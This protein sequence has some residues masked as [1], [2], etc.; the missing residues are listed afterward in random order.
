MENPEGHY[1][2]LGNQL[3]ITS[4]KT[5]RRHLPSDKV[6]YSFKSSCSSAHQGWWSLSEVQSFTN[7]IPSLNNFV[8]KLTSERGV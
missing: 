6:R 4:C 3:N 1:R 5:K 2:S 8:G 7:W